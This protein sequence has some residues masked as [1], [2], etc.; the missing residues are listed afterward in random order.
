MRLILLTCL[1]TTGLLFAAKHSTIANQNLSGFERQALR[2][3]SPR[4]HLSMH[5]RMPDRVVKDK[6]TINAFVPVGK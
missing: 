2:T 3:Q 5:K 6:H 1:L 4:V